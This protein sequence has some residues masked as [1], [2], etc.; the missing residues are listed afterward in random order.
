M[1]GTAQLTVAATVQ[2]AP[3]EVAET[4]V[5][6]EGIGSVTVTPVAVCG[7][8]FVTPIENVTGCPATSGSVSSDLVMARSAAAPTGVWVSGLTEVRSWP[9]TSSRKATRA[10]LTMVLAAAERLT[11]ASKV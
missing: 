11:L 3:G 4:F 8:L 5:T 1:S 2:V 7:P 9:T 6:P 10:S